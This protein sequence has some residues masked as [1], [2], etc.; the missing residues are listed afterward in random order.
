[1]RD[2]SLRDTALYEWV[3]R[4]MVHFLGSIDASSDVAAKQI[5]FRAILACTSYNNEDD[6]LQATTHLNASLMTM[7]REDDLSGVKF[8]QVSKAKDIETNNIRSL[9][10]PSGS[11]DLTLGRLNYEK[12]IPSG[13]NVFCQGSEAFKNSVAIGCRSKKDVQL[14]FDQ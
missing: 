1:M 14:F 11:V 9:S 5:T 2:F 12:E 6:L 10:F 8:T 3:T 4:A 7:A 13:S